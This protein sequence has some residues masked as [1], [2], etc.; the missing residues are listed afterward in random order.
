[1][2]TR[3]KDA[4]GG[5]RVVVTKIGEDP[6]I[7]YKLNELGIK[8]GEILTI[9]KDQPENWL[10]SGIF[11]IKINGKM[12]VLEQHMAELVMVE[13][14]GKMVCILDLRQGEMGKVI[15]VQGELEEKA[16]LMEMGIKPGA[17]IEVIGQ[18]PYDILIF[19]IEGEEKKLSPSLATKIWVTLK[20]KKVQ[21]NYLPQHVLSKILKIVGDAQ[22]LTTLTNMGFV[23]G[24][25][26]KL[27]RREEITYDLGICKNVLFIELHGLPVRLGLD[28]AEQVWVEEV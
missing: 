16:L 28:L 1:M 17:S 4:L 13:K 24:Q 23:E 11:R 6:E 21:S 27:K 14:D 3:L 26:V 25:Y 19:E 15:E 8:H 20:G 7:R 9:L 10:W 12:G 2:N 22:T 5:A 18:F